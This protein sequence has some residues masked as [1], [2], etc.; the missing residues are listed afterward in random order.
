MI[1]LLQVVFAILLVDLV[2]GFVHW[3]EDTFCTET[4]PLIGKWIVT[5]NVLHHRDGNAFVSKGWFAS[6]WDLTL[7]GALVIVA[8]AVAGHCGAAV[9]VFSVL[10]A[11]AN[12]IHKW[13]HQPRSAPWFVRALWTLQL[14]QG[15]VQ[16]HRHHRGAKNTAYCV[17]TPF[18]NPV[19]DRLGFWRALERLVVPFTGAPRREDLRSIRRFSWRQ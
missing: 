9:V 18:V 15:P 19:L 11:H 3:A 6:N 2:S 1:T 4:T 14:L 7:V 12:Q 17:V 8:A 10:G 16:H 13:N 5:P